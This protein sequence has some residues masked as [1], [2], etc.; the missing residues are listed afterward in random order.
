MNLNQLK[1]E[2]VTL[3]QILSFNGKWQ[4][5][6]LVLISHSTIT[7]SLELPQGKNPPGNVLWDVLRCGMQVLLMPSSTEVSAHGGW[8]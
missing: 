8:G 5:K 6:D 7:C 2:K 1:S 3:I 4:A